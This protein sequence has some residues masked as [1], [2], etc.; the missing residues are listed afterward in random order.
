MDYLML[1]DR[2]N[3]VPEHFEENIDLIKIQGKYLESQACRQCSLLL[4]EAER[5]GV[6]I[7]IISA[8]RTKDYQQIL[9]NRSVSEKIGEGLSLEK[10]EKEVSKTLAKPGTVSITQ[11]LL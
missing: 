5:N 11:V 3:A 2:F 4:K 9:W 8:F 7:K 10:A 6:A 1:V